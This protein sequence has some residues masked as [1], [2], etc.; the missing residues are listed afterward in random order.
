MK[1]INSFIYCLKGYYRVNYDYENWRLLIQQLY[2]KYEDIHVLNRAQ[3]VD[4]ILHLAIDERLDFHLAFTL[5][6][7]LKNERDLLP[8][9][10]A[11]NVFKNLLL[12]YD[13]TSASISLRVSDKTF[14]NHFLKSFHGND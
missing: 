11:V 5:T 3:L 8:W 10:A 6:N 12:T 7:Y 2:N 9:F 13:Q 14:C 1:K 4:D